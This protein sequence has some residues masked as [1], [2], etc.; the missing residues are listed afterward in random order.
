MAPTFLTSTLDG[1]EWSASRPRPFTPGERSLGNHWIGGWVGPTTGL[2]I[3]CSC[4][5]SNP[6]VQSV[7]VP[8]ELGRMTEE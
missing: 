2:K 1:G 5:E 6:D 4:R 7:A 8:T 3:S